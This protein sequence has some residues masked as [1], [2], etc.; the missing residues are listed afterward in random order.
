MSRIIAIASSKG[1]VGKST[2]GNHLARTMAAYG[3]K[4]I[5]IETDS[6]LRGLDILLDM[7]DVIYDIYDVVTKN[8]RIEDAIQTSLSE[9]NLALL[10]APIS[11]QSR[12]SFP[13][14]NQV[15]NQLKNSFENIL[16]DL[17]GD[18]DFI[19]NVA[20]MVDMLLVVTTPDPI[21]VR[22]VAIFINYL[23]NKTEKNL[24]M[25][26]IINK[27]QKKLIK[28]GIV[29]NID[30]IIDEIA[31]QLIGVIPQSNRMEIANFC[32][33]GLKKNSLPQKIFNAIF[34]RMNQNSKKLLI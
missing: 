25:R 5:L 16:I 18:F 3:E 14:L 12:L 6:G 13:D 1:G 19:F 29:K 28:R 30:E 2:I 15:C 23:K 17:N 7:H 20:Q 11:F 8:C 9:K 32:G 31:L 22:D 24:K 33:K 27:I 26:L 34:M 10:P 4:T 21:C